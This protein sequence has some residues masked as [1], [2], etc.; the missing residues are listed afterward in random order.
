MLLQD[1]VLIL[2]DP[3]LPLVLATGR[4]SVISELSYHIAHYGEKNAPLLMQ[5]DL[6]LE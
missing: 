5:P 6:S 2:Y 1:K 4:S 3:E